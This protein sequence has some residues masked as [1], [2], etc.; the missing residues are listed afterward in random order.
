MDAEGK[1]PSSITFD[2]LIKQRDQT[3]PGLDL[4]YLLQLLWHRVHCAA[5]SFLLPHFCSG[6][7]IEIGVLKKC[8]LSFL[9]Y[10]FMGGLGLYLLDV[11]VPTESRWGPNYS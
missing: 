1:L 8:T 11:L 3:Q 6:L 7:C 5:V 4:Y 2:S 9:L 10:Q